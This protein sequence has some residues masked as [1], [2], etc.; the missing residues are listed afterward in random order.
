MYN[1]GKAVRISNF[2]AFKKNVQFS[3]LQMQNSGGHSDNSS[4]KTVFKSIDNYICKRFQE[5]KNQII[6]TATITR[7]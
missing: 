4:Y 3:G 2:I 7:I 1:N 6:F 5:N